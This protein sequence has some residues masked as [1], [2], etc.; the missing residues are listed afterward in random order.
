MSNGTETVE[1]SARITQEQLA[2]FRDIFNSSESYAEV[3]DATGFTITRVQY[4]ASRIRKAHKELGTESPL[5]TMARA[6]GGGGI[7]WAV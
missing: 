1:R 6:G 2:E 3:A 5:K 7:N 4:L